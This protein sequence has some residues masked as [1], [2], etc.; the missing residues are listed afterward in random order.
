MPG[1]RASTY[2]PPWTAVLPV[3]LVTRDMKDTQAQLDRAWSL[4]M[5]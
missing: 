1:M 2:L 4:L 3:L 5:P